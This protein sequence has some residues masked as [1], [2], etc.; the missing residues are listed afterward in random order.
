MKPPEASMNLQD[1]FCPYEG[2]VDKHKRGAGNIVWHGRKRPRCKCR[3]CGKTFAYRRGTLFY[4]LRYPEQTVMW[5]VG[6]VAWGCPVAAIVAVLG[7]NER[8]VARWLSRAGESA[9]SFHH[10]HVRRLD[11]QHV[12]VDELRLKR[13]NGLVWLATALAVGSRLW[14]G[15]VAHARRDGYLAQ[16]IITCVY[17][18]ARQRPLL[19][20]FD[21]WS[22][23][24]T[25]CRRIFR[26]P[27]YHV[28]GGRP[29]L[30]PWPTLNLAQVVKSA[31]PTPFARWLL[32]GSATMTRYLLNLTQPSGGTINTSYIE[33]FQATLRAHLA[34][35][36][37]R[38]RCPARWQATLQQRIYIVG[39]LYNFC[40]V[41]QAFQAATPAMMAGLTDHVWSPTEYFWWRPRPF[42]A[43]TV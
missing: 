20:S 5:V 30:I 19:I 25:A 27:C 22:A 17:N 40:T 6:L 23:Y 12:Q 9:H 26:E 28:Q 34:G 31:W 43:S 4:G 29:R 16:Q 39:C 11:L 37:R 42:W 38:T 36:G 8:T 10:Q 21:G 18:W 24:P 35:C 7:I 15:S 32:V 13:Q 41:H 1:V 2:C 3:S 33:R 14:L